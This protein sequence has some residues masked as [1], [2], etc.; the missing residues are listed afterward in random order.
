MGL[1]EG[2]LSECLYPFQTR[3][4]LCEWAT[5]YCTTT[6]KHVCKIIQSDLDDLERPQNSKG[7]YFDLCIKNGRLMSTR[8][9]I[10]N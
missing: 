10:I 9:E 4:R 7:M 1:P 8:P 6:Q 3:A 5:D 2:S